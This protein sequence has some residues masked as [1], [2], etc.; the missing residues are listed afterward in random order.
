METEDR[1]SDPSKEWNVLGVRNLGYMEKNGQGRYPPRELQKD[2]EGIGG[3][4][5]AVGSQ[6]LRGLGE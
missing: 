5:K 1:R 6:S 2:R 3:R 4:E